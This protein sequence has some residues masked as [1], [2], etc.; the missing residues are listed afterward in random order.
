MCR[1][2]CPKE[3]I[4]N[5]MVKNDLKTAR[6]PSG[7]MTCR[8]LPCEN[9]LRRCSPVTPTASAELLYGLN[10]ETSIAVFDSSA[11]N[12]TIDGGFV[13]GLVARECLIAIDFRPASGQV[14]LLGSTETV[15][16][17]NLDSLEATVLE[18]F[19]ATADL[20]GT[21][22]G[23][24]F[25]AAF[26]DG[27]FARIISDTDD[28][29][30]ISGN[31]GQYLLPVEKTDVFYGAGDPNEGAN[32]NIA[33]I[34]YSNSMEVPVTTQQDGIDATLGVLVTV[35]NN[36]GTRASKRNVLPHQSPRLAPNGSAKHRPYLN[37]I[38]PKGGP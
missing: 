21:S 23:F 34:A 38:E 16:A 20:R 6:P 31:T 8:N 35:A 14:Y 18:H 25:N 1:Y 26:T 10:S 13:D 19:S 29:R 5:Y 4:A 32:P 9:P 24:D 11:P 37:G 27:E 28:N 36:A 3:S 2:Q 7:R 22:F 12:V 15:S 33:G 17:F 30:V